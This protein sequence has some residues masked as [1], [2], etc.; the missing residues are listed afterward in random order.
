MSKVSVGPFHVDL[1]G[2]RLP[3]EG[4][5]GECI[6]VFFERYPVEGT[7]LEVGSGTGF[8]YSH[9]P[10]P[11]AGGWIQLEKNR[12]FLEEAL[13]DRRMD[14][15]RG[16]LGSAYTLPFRD[17]SL[18]AVCGYTSFDSFFDLPRAVGEA[19]RVLRPGGRFFHLLDLRPHSNVVELSPE[20]II[21][22]EVLTSQGHGRGVS[23]T[24]ELGWERERAFEAKLRRE[25]EVRGFRSV[26]AGEIE[27]RVLKRK[28]KAHRAQDST[29]S[30]A[31]LFRFDR[32]EVKSHALPFPLN[33]PYRLFMDRVLE[34]AR[35]R[36]VTAERF[37]V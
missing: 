5:L 24:Y 27:G 23:R 4:A 30:D 16:L 10:G 6:R 36:Y 33:I 22:L 35:V 34:W 1:G 25:L 15:A 32:G 20:E 12:L 11:M 19:A 17:G 18:D 26:E 37:H 14:G 28:L 29:F 2:V 8:L 7:I 3:V 13:R 9:L 31:V 21:R